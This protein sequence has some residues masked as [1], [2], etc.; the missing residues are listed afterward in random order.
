MEFLELESLG[1]VKEDYYLKETNLIK[2]KKISNYYHNK[3]KRNMLILFALSMINFV[4]F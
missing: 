1:Y 2:M 3:H 4:Q